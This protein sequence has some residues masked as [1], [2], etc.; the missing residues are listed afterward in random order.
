MM[1]MPVA[2]TAAGRRPCTLATRFC[3]STAAIQVVA[4]REGHD[5]LA[6]SAVGA[7]GTDVAHALDAVDRLFQRDGYGLLYRLGVGSHIVASSPTPAEASAWGTS[8]PEE[9]MQIAPA[10][11]NKQRAHRRENRPMNEKI[12]E[13][14]EFLS[15]L[16]R[17]KAR[18]PAR[19]FA[20]H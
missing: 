9:G 5:D 19:I 3:T 1:V 8:P 18:Q 7:G 16:Q 15:R 11:N 2:L 4:G 17:A 6:A 10:Q 20:W 14:D 13:Q 12:D